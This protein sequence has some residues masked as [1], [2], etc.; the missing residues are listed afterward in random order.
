MTTPSR[1]L[2]RAAGQPARL[3]HVRPA[4][5]FSQSLSDQQL[6]GLAGDVDDL[7]AA[8]LEPAALRR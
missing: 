7:V 6:G 2:Y 5:R 3:P 1:A 8:L 4:A